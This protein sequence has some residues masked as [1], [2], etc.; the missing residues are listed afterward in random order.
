MTDGKP[1]RS[2]NETV[3]KKDGSWWWLNKTNNEVEG[4]FAT[5]KIARDHRHT[6]I[7]TEKV[8]KSVAA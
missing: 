5:R 2:R 1:K 7:T 3:Y 4:P 8:I 6:V